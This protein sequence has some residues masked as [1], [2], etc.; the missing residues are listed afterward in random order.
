[1]P[2]TLGV[3]GFDEL[4]RQWL[5]LAERRLAYFSE[6]YRSGRWRRY[7]TAE[8]FADQVVD[9]MKAVTIWR[10]LAGQT[11]VSASDTDDLRPAA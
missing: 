10:K 6:L 8:S 5:T 4:S 11:P 1:M 2:D 9:V 7:Y 3:P